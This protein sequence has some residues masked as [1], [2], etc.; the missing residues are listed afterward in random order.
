MTDNRKEPTAVALIRIAYQD[1][2]SGESTEVT[3]GP[4]VF[5]GLVH[6]TRTLGRE[7]A[8]ALLHFGATLVKPE[9]ATVDTQRLEYVLTAVERY[10]AQW[11]DPAELAL[12]LS[13]E[14]YREHQLTDAQAALFATALLGQPVSAEVWQQ[15]VD[16]WAEAQQRPPRDGELQQRRLDDQAP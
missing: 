11:E 15:R 4:S 13:Y 3:L 14:Q 8:R 9:L 16:R 6:T 1:A 2:D 5:V 12:A 10:I 7:H